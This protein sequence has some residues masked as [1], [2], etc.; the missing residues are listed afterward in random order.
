MPKN[1]RAWASW[2]F[3]LEQ[4]REGRLSSS[5]HYWMNRLQNVSERRNYFVSVDYHG[6]I[7]PGK[8][9]WDYVYDHPTFDERGITAQQH[10]PG[11]NEQGPVL[12]CGSYF[13]NG[14]HEDALT[15]ALNAANQLKKR[16]E[17]LHELMPV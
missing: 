10:L 6:E 7:D 8:I 5:T 15:S 12:F 16:T 2:N 14:F 4:L 1:R 3:R 11:L 9:H 17:T 13:K